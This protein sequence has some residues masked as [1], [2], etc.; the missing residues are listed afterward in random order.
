MLWTNPPRRRGPRRSWL[1]AAAAIVAVGGGVLAFRAL[2][3]SGIDASFGTG[4][5]ASG[6]KVMVPAAIAPSVPGFVSTLRGLTDGAAT[7]TA[8]GAP[9]AIEPGGSFTMYIPQGTTEIHLVATGADGSTGESV[10]AVTDA[11]PAP[12][13]PA[14]AALHVRAEDWANPASAS[15][16]W[17][18]R[19]RAGSTPSSSTSRTRSASSATPVKSRWR[20]PSG[21]PSVTTTPDRHSTS[22]TPRVSA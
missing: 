15:S 8:N 19:R 1:V 18:S 12:T 20:R 22:C 3:S 7:L 6:P 4:P 17:T 10:V 11:V 16:S 13:Y 21:R 9:V 5:A 2:R 14:T